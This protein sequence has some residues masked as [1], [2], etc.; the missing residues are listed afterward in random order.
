MSNLSLTLRRWIPAFVVMAVIYWFSSVPSDEM[1][2]FGLIDLLVKKGGHFVGYGLLA[3]TYFHG[4]KDT[5]L[6]AG[7]LSWLFAV[8]YAFSDEFHQSF[9]PGRQPSFIDIVIDAAGAALVL[10]FVVM[11]IKRTR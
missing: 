8:L 2:Q 7:W 6:S 5:N 4:L 3:W 9:V 11:R 1:L 10:A